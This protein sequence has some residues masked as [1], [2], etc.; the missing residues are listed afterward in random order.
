M[1]KWIRKPGLRRA[2]G[3]S[4]SRGFLMSW[5]VILSLRRR[6]R[7]RDAA[8][9]NAIGGMSKN[10]AGSIAVVLQSAKT[11]EYRDIPVSEPGKVNELVSKHFSFREY[12]AVY[13]YI[14]DNA[15]CD[16]MKV[17]VDVEK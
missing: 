7:L 9:I 16:V 6:I 13:Q 14:D 11:I 10:I 17:I 15:G 2:F 3:D 4:G 12:A 8:K 1:E 5:N